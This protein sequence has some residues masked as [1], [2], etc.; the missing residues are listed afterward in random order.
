MVTKKLI[1]IILIFLFVSISIYP[2]TNIKSYNASVILR[3]EATKNLHI[4]SKTTFLSLTNPVPNKN[5]INAFI[6]N[7]KNNYNFSEFIFQ[8]NDSIK[9]KQSELEKLKN[10]IN[11]LEND[12]KQISSK[13]KKTYDVIEKY[14]K[15]TFLLNK[16]INQYRKEVKVKETEI[17]SLNNQIINLQNQ[18]KILKENYAKQVVAIYK[19][20][21]DNDLIY[22]LNSSSL[23]QAILRY[24]YLQKF[25][26]ARKKDLD[27]MKSLG[28]EL[29][30]SKEKLEREK[31]ERKNLLTQKESEENTLEKKVDE[32]KIFL[33]QIKNN[34]LALRKELDSKKK[35]EQEI[36]NLIARL[37]E[38]QR[39][40]EEE[41]RKKLIA[42][43]EKNS[44]K[45]L[46]EEE[47]IIPEINYSNV[48]NIAFANLKGR[49]NWPIS[50]GS[51][52]KKFGQNI[53]SSL[54]TVTLNYG[55]DIKAQKDFNVRSVADGV[56]SAIEW[57]PGFGNIV[58]ITHSSKYR[59]VY[60][61]LGIINVSENESVKA[62]EIIGT[63]AE[64]LEGNILHFEIWDERESL[65]PE[66]WL[67][68]K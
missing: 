2:N 50:R 52:Y 5:K 64:S 43:K 38:E 14:N 32:Q 55:I 17:S 16:I 34:K 58:I 63:L 3:S 22:L 4:K 7:I 65:N 33:K 35:A 56:V 29:A 28:R 42:S 8:Q 54:N 11:S 59:T 15:Q 13:E 39:R 40:K 66:I 24:K 41:E 49:M 21:Y 20:I 61:H 62:G 25:S 10:E 23:R 44:S 27:K 48:K 18:I 60:G 30:Y 46:T 37:I 51:I 31:I 57:L 1:N 12:I 47:N 19:G 9:T 67:V 53:N 26:D 45:D 6:I 68:R 36:K